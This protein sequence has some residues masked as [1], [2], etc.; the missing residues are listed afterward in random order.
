MA[1]NSHKTVQGSADQAEISSGEILAPPLARE[2]DPTVE[3]IILEPLEE[4]ESP[5][6]CAQNSHEPAPDRFRRK[7][8]PRIV[9][10]SIDTIHVDSRYGST[11][12]KAGAFRRLV[13]RMDFLSEEGV[14]LVCSALRIRVSVIDGRHFAFGGMLS[15]TLAQQSLLT[16]RD[17]TVELYEEVSDRDVFDAAVAD[18]FILYALMR[19]NDEIDSSFVMMLVKA[20]EVRPEIFARNK[21]TLIESFGRSPRDF[22]SKF[23]RKKPIREAEDAA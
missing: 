23:S 14:R 5:A 11:L 4:V 19:T 22:R 20:H 6:R 9:E 3:E 8:Q 21:K 18:Q 13:P 15:Y 1:Q 12:W 17:I 7:T 10:R 16:S 2:Q